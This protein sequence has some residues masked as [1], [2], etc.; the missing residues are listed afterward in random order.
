MFPYCSKC[1]KSTLRWGCIPNNSRDLVDSS[2]VLPIV[3]SLRRWGRVY[4]V[5]FV[6]E[7]IIPVHSKECQVNAT[8]KLNII[9]TRV[10]EALV[11]NHCQLCQVNAAMSVYTKSTIVF[12]VIGLV[13]CQ[14]CQANAMV[15]VYTKLTLVIEAIVPVYRRVR[16]VNAAKACIPIPLL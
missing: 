14:V 3:S 15:E 10:I 16:Q 6:L 4:K 13:Y 8:V 12:M 9:S 5:T 1:A 2:C 11:S 7:V